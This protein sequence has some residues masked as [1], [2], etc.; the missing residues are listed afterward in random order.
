MAA[1]V[2]LESLEKR[3]SLEERVSDADQMVQRF[4]DECCRAGVGVAIV[5]HDGEHIKVGR[6]MSFA[7]TGEMFDLGKEHMDLESKRELESN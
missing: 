5:F 1:V 2:G 6:N 3:V 7:D 4:I